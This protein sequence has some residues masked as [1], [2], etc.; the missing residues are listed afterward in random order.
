MEYNKAQKTDSSFGKFLDGYKARTIASMEPGLNLKM[1]EL[2]A[3]TDGII[4]LM[5][6]N[7]GDKYIIDSLERS[8]GVLTVPD[9]DVITKASIFGETFRN[10][11]PTIMNKPAVIGEEE[12]NEKFK[13]I[14]YNFAEL[15]KKSENDTLINLAI[16][17]GDFV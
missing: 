4:T 6:E 11:I 12:F 10:T 9:M 16:E 17:M 7:S 15:A 5:R 8:C 2:R 3:L 13:K 1:E 14:I